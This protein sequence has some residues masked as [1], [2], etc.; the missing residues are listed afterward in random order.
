MTDLYEIDRLS[1][2][3]T[4]QAGEPFNISTNICCNETGDQCPSADVGIEVGGIPVGQMGFALVPGC[5]DVLEPGRTHWRD[6][7]KDLAY[8]DWLS[9]NKEDATVTISS[10]GEYKVT[11]SVEG[12]D[13]VSK[14]ITVEEPI[15]EY[16]TS[17][18]SITGCEIPDR[19][20]NG[21]QNTVA[22]TVKNNNP[23]EGSVKLKWEIIEGFSFITD[24]VTIPANSSRTIETTALIDT[25][26]SGSMGTIGHRKPTISF[27]KGGQGTYECGSMFIEEGFRPENITLES[28]GA[29]DSIPYKGNITLEATLTSNNPKDGSV[30]MMWEMNGDMYGS[31]PFNIPANDSVTVTSEIDTG[32]VDVVPGGSIEVKTGIEGGD[33]RKRCGTVAVE[34]KEQEQDPDNP[35]DGD[36]GEND[37]NNKDSNE[38]K[39]GNGG[40]DED[41]GSI[42]GGNGGSNIGNGDPIGEERPIL[43]ERNKK[44]L[45]IGSLVG[46]GLY[47][48][49]KRSN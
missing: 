45:G 16:D 19:V 17:K 43:T 41:L 40:K 29:S 7:Q 24:S 46:A 13:R 25:S 39:T 33:S 21:T 22:A 27:V 30:A 26:E 47:I 32:N 36:T 6:D 31:D 10:G 12:Y 9:V 8:A 3:S 35:D 28:C 44:I 20:V 23:K 42:G 15:P 38:G 49:A 14:T 48:A 37:G 4:V 5:T 34:Q 11:L 1:V 2:P 18:V